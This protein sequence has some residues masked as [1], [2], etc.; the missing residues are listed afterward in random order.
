MSPYERA[1]MRMAELAPVRL[2]GA[3]AGKRGVRWARIER[4]LPSDEAEASAA[5]WWLRS[6][7]IG[8][9]FRFLRGESEALLVIDYVERRA[10]QAE[11]TRAHPAGRRGRC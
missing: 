6:T 4:V 11:P 2:G 10:P 3:Y 7:E 1:V 5:A 9:S 8:G